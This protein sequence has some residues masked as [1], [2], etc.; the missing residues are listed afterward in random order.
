MRCREILE[1][2]NGSNDNIL[3]DIHEADALRMVDPKGSTAQTSD[4]ISEARSVVR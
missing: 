3:H 4:S 1:V 2:G